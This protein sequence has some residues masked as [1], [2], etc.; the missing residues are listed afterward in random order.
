MKF[1][2]PE[3]CKTVKEKFDKT[4]Y[5]GE[6]CATSYILSEK[7]INKPPQQIT[8]TI[9]KNPIYPPAPNPRFQ[10]PNMG[11]QPMMPNMQRMPINYMLPM[12]IPMGN[13]AMN[14]Q[15]QMQQMMNRPPF[16]MAPVPNFMMRP[17]GS[18]INQHQFHDQNSMQKMQNKSNPPMHQINQKRKIDEP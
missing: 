4:E 15:I 3:I 11:M 12:Q 9:N 1:S 18:N 17:M 16:G 13:M 2:N 6:K 14:P 8:D 7:T 5:S 10:I